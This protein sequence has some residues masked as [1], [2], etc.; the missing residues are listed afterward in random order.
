VSPSGGE[1]GELRAEHDRLAA[2]L[3]IRRS[4]DHVRQGAYGLFFA[5]ISSGMAVKLAW[6]RWWSVRPTRFKG[7]P[8][9][10][11]AVA[12]VA[13]ALIAF[14]VRAFLRARR[15][16][17]EENVAFARLRELRARLGLDP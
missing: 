8:I 14:T 2:R 6:D 13:L 12:A 7:P 5:F 9:Y 17:A 16:M 1:G 3:E 11:F 15:H 4:I 10:F